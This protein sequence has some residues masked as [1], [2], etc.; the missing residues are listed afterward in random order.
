MAKKTGVYIDLSSLYYCVTQ[1][2][3]H[4]KINYKAV[5]DYIKGLGGEVVVCNAYGVHNNSEADA[6]IRRLETLGIATRYKAPR[7]AG[8][9]FW[10]RENWT[11]GIVVDM[12]T[13]L[14]ELDRYIICSSEYGVAD[15]VQTLMDNKKEVIEL[16][17]NI[18]DDIKRIV[19]RCIEIP[20]SMLES[21]HPKVKGQPEVPAELKE[22][23]D[24]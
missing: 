3:G 11:V 22:K 10:Y 2:F 17:I 12:L 16:S 1:K 7:T 13:K 15:M 23:E 14:P 20:E 4:R 9:K 5:L 8:G 24:A 6:F 18:T 19:P 21:K